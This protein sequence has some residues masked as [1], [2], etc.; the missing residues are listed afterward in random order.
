MVRS[1]YNM[2]VWDKGAAAWVNTATRRTLREEAAT[3]VRYKEMG[4]SLHNGGCIGHP[5]IVVHPLL[6]GH[7]PPASGLH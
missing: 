1:I 6:H 7:G 2:G 5:Q 3:R 4:H